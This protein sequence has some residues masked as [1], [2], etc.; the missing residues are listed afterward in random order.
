MIYSRF[1][2]TE[3]LLFLKEV[4]MLAELDVETL[5]I[6]A[7]GCHVKRVKRGHV[8]FRRGDSSKAVYLVQSGSIAEFAGGP[9]EL[10]MVVKERHKGDYF[11]EM[12]ILDNN[13]R[14]ATAHV[15]EDVQ[16]LSISRVQF[17]NIIQQHPEVAVSMLTRMNSIVRT[18][19]KK[20]AL[21]T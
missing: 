20:L 11:G 5:E 13:L 16:L 4:P 12:G 10:E 1:S 8:V 2:T 3:I 9:N 17:Q 6:L 18:L 14:S 15:I 7:M 21:S 19:N